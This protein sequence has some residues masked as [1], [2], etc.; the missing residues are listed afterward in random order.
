MLRARRR[1]S[2]F[3]LTEVMVASGVLLFFV[4]G[5]L[6]ALLMGIRT[7]DLSVQHYRATS[8]A[9]NRVQRARSFSYS[10]LPLLQESGVRVTAMVMP[11]RMV[12][13]GGR[14]RSIRI[15]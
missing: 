14:H 9:R 12:I 7:L 8:I 10:S 11:I 13:S 5:L 3:T 6:A 4:L 15:P 2:G 1:D